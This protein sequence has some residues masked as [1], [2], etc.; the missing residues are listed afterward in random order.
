MMFIYSNLKEATWCMFDGYKTAMENTNYIVLK[1]L[2]VCMFYPFKVNKGR[3]F[4]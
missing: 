2:K 3:K 1:C 4:E